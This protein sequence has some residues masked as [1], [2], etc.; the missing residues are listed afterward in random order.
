MQGLGAKHQVHIGRTLH[1]G[2]AFLACHT[3]THANN[4][5]GLSFFEVAGTT[6]VGEDFFLGLLAHRAGVKQNDIGLLGRGRGLKPMR[7]A[8]NVCHL[9]GIVVIHLA[10]KAANVEFGSHCVVANPC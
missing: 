7:L 4:E 5:S 1:N 6:K 3:A 8:Q 9:A 10:A 2:L